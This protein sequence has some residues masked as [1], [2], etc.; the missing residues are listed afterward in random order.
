MVATDNKDTASIAKDLGVEVP[1]IRPEELSEGYVDVFDV[2]EYAMDQLEQEQRYYDIVILLEE[3]YPFRP[4]GM[5]DN[6]VLKLVNEGY[7][8]VVAGKS[9][10]RSIWVETSDKIELLGSEENLSMPNA[11]KESKN[12]I[13]LLGLCCVTHSASLRNSIIFS[14]KVGIV[15]MSDPLTL[16]SARNDKELKLASILDKNL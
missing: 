5:I 14:G 6:M 12:I 4:A 13:G 8:T 11:L 15:K 7:D 2:V 1:F 9:E 16:V 3:I 10:A